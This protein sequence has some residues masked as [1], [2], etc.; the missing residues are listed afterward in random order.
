MATIVKQ[1]KKIMKL[2]KKKQGEVCSAGRTLFGENFQ[3][4]GYFKDLHS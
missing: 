1:G 3:M 4:V 2:R